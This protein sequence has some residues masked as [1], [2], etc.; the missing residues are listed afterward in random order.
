MS[1]SNQKHIKASV[2]FL[3]SES[4]PMWKHPVNPAPPVVVDHKA[5][6]K[7][8]KQERQNRKKK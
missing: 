7:K 5:L 3:N 6:R 1:K 8:K 4:G 2:A